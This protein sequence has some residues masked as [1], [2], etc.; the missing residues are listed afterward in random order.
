MVIDYGGAP[1]YRLIH[2]AKLAQKEGVIKGI[3]LHQGETNT[4][5]KQWPQY[6]KK[7]YE[8]ILN[9]LGLN[10]EDVPL[11]VGEVVHESKKGKCSSM[12]P[13]I[14]TIPEVIS[15]AY[16]VSSKGCTERGDRVHFDS[17]GVRKMGKRYAEKMLKAK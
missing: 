4:G 2:L 11:V 8:N 3:I 14:R 1:Y 15:T 17:K 13:I 6:V 7:I 10:A 12:N 5:D 16:V 9:D